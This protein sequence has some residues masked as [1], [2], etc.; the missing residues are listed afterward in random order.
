[1]G[2]DLN[3]FLC[4]VCLDQVEDLK[5]TF[6]NCRWTQGFW[7]KVSQWC[8]LNVSNF[9]SPD[10][11]LDWIDFKW[12]KRKERRLIELIFIAYIN[13]IWEHRNG[14]S[15]DKKETSPD[16]AFSKMQDDAYSWISNRANKIVID[17]SL[18]FQ[19]LH[20]AVSL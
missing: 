16:L 14:V 6:I 5:Q 19:S 20:K 9:Y 11:T 17:R 7:L 8:D 18:W 1:M 3:D 15:F 10:S 4:P 13:I 12:E 2:V